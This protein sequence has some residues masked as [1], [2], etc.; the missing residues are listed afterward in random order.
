MSAYMFGPGLKIGEV[1]SKDEVGGKGHSLLIMTKEKLPVPPGFIIP[2]SLMKEYLGA[3]MVT[4]QKVETIVTE[5]Y[6]EL[7]K[8]LGRPPVVAVRSGAPISMPGMM[9]TI[10]N[11]GMLKSGEAFNSLSNLVGEVS[12]LDSYRRLLMMYGTTVLGMRAEKFDS[13]VKQEKKELLKAIQ[14]SEAA[15]TEQGLNLPT[16]PI[17]QI[18]MSVEAVFRSWNSERAIIYREANK[19]SNDMGTAAIVQAMVFGNAGENS[20]SGVGFT[21]DPSTG[22]N[23]LFGEYL[24]NAQGEDVVAGTH[25]PLQLTAMLSTPE[26]KVIYGKLEDMA[27]KLE[28]MYEDMVDFEFTV[29]SGALY[30]LQS[31]VGKRTDKAAVRIALDL[32]KGGAVDLKSLRKVLKVSQLFGAT[33]ATSSKASHKFASNK[34]L[35]GGGGAAIGT[36]VMS[37]ESPLL[38]EGK[39]ACILVVEETTPD[40]IGGMLKAK[41][42]LTMKGGVTSHAAVVARSLNL[43]C[44][45]S[46]EGLHVSD[47]TATLKYGDTVITLKEGDK[48]AICGDTGYVWGN[49]GKFSIEEAV[50]LVA[51]LGAAVAEKQNLVLYGYAKDCWMDALSLKLQGLDPLPGMTVVNTG[52]AYKNSNDKVLWDAIGNPLDSLVDK[53]A[54]PQFNTLKDLIEHGKNSKTVGLTPQIIEGVFGSADIAAAFSGMNGLPALKLLGGGPVEVI[55]QVLDA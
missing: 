13:V 51:E 9:D 11:V 18:V 8:M 54:V 43:P 12:A 16:D 15:F 41:G 26:W 49:T 1:P 10:L 47:G 3:P 7:H 27:E 21:R 30:M 29:E 25:T 52:T 48:I 38:M 44:V 40:D 55:S 17:K 5:K 32:L 37:S 2:I 31:R 6:A 50:S 35:A 23:A 45:T 14:N 36:I 42:F 22:E 24:V 39:E 4:M 28:A 20:C 33:K 53:D 46:C 19:I 34:G